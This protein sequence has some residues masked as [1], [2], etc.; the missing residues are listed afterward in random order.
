M[1]TVFNGNES[2]TLGVELELQLV[3]RKTGA[4]SNSIGRILDRVPQKWEDCFKPELM[5][6]YCEINTG[7]CN[8]VAEVETDLS[9]KLRWAYDAAEQL[10]LTFIWGSAHPFSRWD[11][12][13]ASP[14][15]RYAWL[16][17]TM[18][19]VGRRLVVFG[20]HVHV[21]LDSG[22][23]A[24]QM[25]DR[26]LRHLPT[27]LALSASSP[28]WCG[29]DT[30]MMSYRSKIMEALPTAGLPHPLRNWS[31][32]NWL[33]D[34]L[35]ATDFIRSIREIW[36]DVRPHAGFGTVEVRIMDMPLNMQHLLGLVALVQSTVA[37]ISENIDRG[38]YQFDSHPMI[39][40]QNKWQAVR[41]GMDATL[42]DFDTM[43]AVPA[44]QMAKRMIENCTPAAERLGCAAQLEGL[45][46]IIENGTS[47]YRQKRIWEKTLDARQVVQYLM[48]QSCALEPV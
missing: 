44:R 40:K 21:G 41:Y 9:E 20:L 38:A 10:G 35:I 24:I 28:I 43:L 47:A 4:L 5:Q 13:Q 23:K 8:T 42:V 3:D 7:V 30:G 18:Q 25:C 12:Q 37:S 34:H 36:W 27:M 48:E 26:L 16:L 1:S 19:D 31:E 46:D 32:Y 14:G 17:E 33:I 11:D 39:A 45:H 2:H 6:S 22:D 29:R 15:E